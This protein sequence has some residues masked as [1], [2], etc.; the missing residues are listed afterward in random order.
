MFALVKMT[1]VRKSAIK[2]VLC[3]HTF[4]SY[5]GIDGRKVHKTFCVGT[6]VYLS[7]ILQKPE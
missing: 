2:K 4:E 5:A 6:M 1:A 3:Q 7:A